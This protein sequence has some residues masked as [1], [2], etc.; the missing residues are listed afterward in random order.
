MNAPQGTSYLRVRARDNAGNI[1]TWTTGFTFRYDNTPPLNPETVTESG[2]ADSDVWQN[3]ISDPDFNWSAGTDTHSGIAAYT[4]YW[5]SNSAGN[6][7]TEAGPAGYNPPES[8]N[9]IYYL[10]IKTRDIAGNESAVQTKFIFKHDDN[11][12]TNPSNFIDASGTSD[13]MW[14]N[15]S[16]DPAFSWDAGSDLL[17]GLEGYEYTGGL[18]QAEHQ[19]ILFRK[20]VLILPP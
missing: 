2:G 1:G 4:V 18:I 17:S 3:N 10:R 19:R 20:I 5:G 8:A 11:P 7:G 12:P 16:D 13:N 9:G 6:P 15:T 14:Q